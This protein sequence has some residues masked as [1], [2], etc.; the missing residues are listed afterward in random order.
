M[1]MRRVTGATGAALVLLGFLAFMAVGSIRSPAGPWLVM[2]A[3][4]VV[5][6]GFVLLWEAQVAWPE[7]GTAYPWRRRLAGLVV[8]LATLASAVVTRVL[9]QVGLPHS[10][11]ADTFAMLAGV[12][13]GRAVFRR[14]R[15]A[16]DRRLR[17]RPLG[18]KSEVE[19]T[20]P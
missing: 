3:L 11:V 12:A 6:V 18:E 5:T 13:V 17:S 2:V 20:A 16:A 14:L 9:L 7:D 10:G 4:L 1:A 8:G 19:S 15:D